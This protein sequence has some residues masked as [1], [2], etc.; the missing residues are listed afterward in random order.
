MPAHRQARLMTRLTDC[1]LSRS[2][3]TV[4]Q[5]LT[6]APDRALS[7]AGRLQPAR[8]A[9]TGQTEG[10]GLRGMALTSPA[11]SRSGLGAADGDAQALG[12]L[13]QVLGRLMSGVANM[14][15][16]DEHRLLDAL[17]AIVG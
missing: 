15:R 9:S 2:G 6:P 5:R 12:D 10:S 14:D 7:D 8:S 13:D 16:D 4:S 3:P 17:E 11:P 1:A